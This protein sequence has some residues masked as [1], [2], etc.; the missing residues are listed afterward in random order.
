MESCALNGSRAQAGMGCVWR[1]ELIDEGIQA[2][3][4]GQ[5]LR[6]KGPFGAEIHD[7]L[8]GQGREYI[9]TRWA[10]NTQAGFLADW[11]PSRQ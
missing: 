2:E 1:G 5:G 7:L 4:E 8:N 6:D 10:M 9:P 3:A 11:S